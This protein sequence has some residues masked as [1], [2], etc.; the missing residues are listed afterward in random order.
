LSTRSSTPNSERF[1]KSEAGA[2]ASDKPS[3][4][5]G[6]VLSKRST[7][8]VFTEETRLLDNALTKVRYATSS[9]NSLIFA[10]DGIPFS[11]LLKRLNELRKQ[12]RTSFLPTGTT[13]PNVPT[14]G[15]DNDITK[16]HD[17]DETSFGKFRV[18]NLKVTL[19]IH[20]LLTLLWTTA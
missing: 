1:A 2:N 13:V 20:L 9:D 4:A 10:I 17:K 12:A 16:F 8:D 14:W 18:E 11:R 19:S 7:H 5:D 3:L 15:R 6:K